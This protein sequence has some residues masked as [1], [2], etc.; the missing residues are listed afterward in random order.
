MTKAA[1]APVSEASGGKLA[2][3]IMHFARVLRHAG[4]PIGT[5]QMIDAISATDSGCLRNREDFY[6]MLH[7]LFVR[8]REHRA[9]FDQAFH[10]FWQKPK[11]LEQLMSMFFQEVARPAG[12][13]KKKPG[14][15]RLASAMFEGPDI[16][17]T[18]KP[19]R[20][21]LEVD[22]SYTFNADEV[23]RQKDFE[24]MSALE[25]EDALRA[26]AQLRLGRFN[27]PTRRH[28]PAAR[29]G[30]D[31]RRTLKAAARS[32]SAA[33]ILK[34]R[35]RKLKQPPLVVLC[36]IS[37][38]MSGYSRMFLHFLH[39]LMTDRS[40]VHVFLFGTRLTNITRALARR[41]VDEAVEEVT[42]QVK[43]WSGGTR[44]GACLREFNF[45]WAR[46]VLAQGAHVI[47]I[48]DGLDRDNGE[49]LEAEIS[50]LAKS[51]KHLIWLNPLL[52]YDGFEARAGG[53]RIIL[54]HVDEF[55]PVHNLN[56]L[57]DLAR[58]LTGTGIKVDFH[59]SPQRWLANGGTS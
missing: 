30:V 6:W 32:A 19:P 50:R 17:S 3:N 59:S 33:N 16:K 57:E 45:K 52:R 34:F 12:N 46:R 25:Q 22:A 38:S 54:A 40:R 2:E 14:E 39:A 51:A 31:M 43:D 36:D 47:I 9:V 11:M 35:T 24:Q 49:A 5:G 23:L 10:V 20:D 55:R 42:C 27:V 13:E 18:R 44:I 26:I 58:A 56:S 8:R 4:L 41:D 21:M 29:G 37:G 53:I 1:T 15:R 48:S 28:G 7:S